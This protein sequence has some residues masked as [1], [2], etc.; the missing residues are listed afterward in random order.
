[1]VAA[2]LPLLKSATK[3]KLAV[4]LFTP[5]TPAEKTSYALDKAEE[6]YKT[7]ESGINPSVQTVSDTYAFLINP[8]SE[9]YPS[10]SAV[11]FS[12]ILRL[13]P[14]KGRCE[15][16]LFPIRLMMLSSS[17]FYPQHA[18]FLAK[19]AKDQISSLG[20]QLRVHLEDM[21]KGKS[22]GKKVST[23]NMKFCNV[24]IRVSD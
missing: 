23:E 16:V 5:P 10:V 12:A 8:P 19:E 22:R 11:G 2:V 17:M 7:I 15:T 9:F 13:Y 18:A 1:M 6:Y 3:R 21:R 4:A 20:S 14:A 24:S